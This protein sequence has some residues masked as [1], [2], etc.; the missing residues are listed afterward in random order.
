[1]GQ[2]LVRTPGDFGLAGLP[3]DDPALLDW[4]A[5]DF[6][7]HEWSIKRLIRQI[8]LSATYQQ[9]ALYEPVP[10]SLGYAIRVPRRLTAEQLRDAMLCV[11]G[12]LTDKFDGPAIWP[13]LPNEVLEANPA[14]LDDNELK[15]KGWYPSPEADQL[16]RSL[17]LVQKRNTRIPILETFDLPDNSVSCSRRGTSIVAPQAITMLNGDLS[18]KSARALAGIVERETT[19]QPPESRVDRAFQLVLQ[20]QPTAEEE[21]ACLP[22]LNSR[23]LTEFCRVVL[24]LT[25]FAYVD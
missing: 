10:E 16:C 1:M 18:V 3:P 17:F 13:D 5:S 19:D 7:Q 12:S 8:V 15:I 20:R 11:S 6:V 4:L 23:G 25:E 21:Q 2:G 14:F 9:A 22:L 24:N